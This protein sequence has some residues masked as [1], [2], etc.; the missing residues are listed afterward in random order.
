MKLGKRKGHSMLPRV[1][2]EEGMKSCLSKSYSTQ[3]D[4]NEFYNDA[5]IKL[6]DEWLEEEGFRSDRDRKPAKAGGFRHGGAPHLHL[7][8]VPCVV[9][10]CHAMR[11]TCF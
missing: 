3:E 5:T 10:V 1:M 2:V 11:G 4:F 6:L 9:L 7:F 8:E